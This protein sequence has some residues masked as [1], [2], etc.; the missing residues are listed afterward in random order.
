MNNNYVRRKKI[1]LSIIVLSLLSAFFADI[2]P[3]NWIFAYGISG[4]TEK[5]GIMGILY[6][7]IIVS[8]VLFSLFNSRIKWHIN[9]PIF[10]ILIYVCLFYIFTDQYIGPPRT[11]FSFLI[12]FV[13]SAMIIPNLT[14]I[15]TRIFLRA[16]MFYPFF[17]IF[18][19]NSV[20]APIE[21]W[22]NAIS[23]DASYAFLIPVVGT[24]VYIA[25]YLRNDTRMMKIFMLLLSLINGV[26]L[27]QLF[28]Q[29]SRGTLLSIALLVV[30]LFIFKKKQNALGA[31][32]SGGKLF[33]FFF[34]FFLFFCV[35]YISL[36]Q[37]IADTLAL[38][39][40][41]SRALLKILDLNA[42]GDISNGRSEL[43]VITINGIIEHPLWG[44]GFDRYHANTELLYPHNFLLQLLY[45][46][47]LLYF[48]VV[49]TPV[50]LG[51]VR[52][53][54]TCNR[55]EFA[56]MVFLMFS[57]V[58]GALFSNNLYANSILWMFFGFSISKSFVYK[59]K[60][61]VQYK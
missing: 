59:P 44:N 46:G 34:L 5:V 43:N 49:L 45:D 12:V 41:E 1:P 8:I 7:V 24:I 58:P 6:P 31:T 3:V 17:A 16:L 42:S 27:W 52:I 23:M 2:K 57:S 60:M 54:K 48:L 26:F 53:F 38:Y 55:D 9:P 15:D 20:F 30:F 36:F 47:G 25:F 50:V 13:L 18:R 33:L 4:D 37:I 11:K 21:D 29:G 61:P 51:I 56:I 10:F 35:G 40:V 14:V 32:Y 19:L 22:K 39:G 28:L